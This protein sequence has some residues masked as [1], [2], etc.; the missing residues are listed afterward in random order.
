VTCQDAREFFSALV[1][2]A[3]ALEER[4]LLEAH[5]LS[6]A[7]CRRE[8]E[9]FRRTVALLRGVEP[10]RAPVG[11]VDRALARARPTPW[12]RRLLRRLFV[13]LPVKL[14]IEAAA[15]VLIAVSAVYVFQRTPELQQAARQEAPLRAPA[16]DAP[17]PA[18]PKPETAT[19]P[20][21]VP[22]TP[23]EPGPSAS[24]PA[25]SG[26]RKDKEGVTDLREAAPGASV[27]RDVAD[28]AGPVGRRESPSAQETKKTE[29]TPAAPSPLSKAPPAGGVGSAGAS[30]ERRAN[31]PEEKAESAPAAPPGS[32]VH[33]FSTRALV[34]VDVSGRLVVKDRQAAATALADLVARLGGSQLARRPD[35]GA[36]AGEIVE[37]LIPRAA[38][39]AFTQELGRLG[40]WR[41]D[42]ELPELPEL[43]R[44]VVHLTE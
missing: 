6:C 26:A 28:P 9:R 21:P 36:A 33:R 7:D 41:S 5:L 40:E 38:Y 4:A 29:A 43:V 3:L 22:T 27:S 8:L 31:A 2:E 25:P 39:A 1:D 42:T 30:R 13:P 14:P 15:V 20:R 17:L 35:P 19:P 24:P 11:F 44:A 23:R 37:I 34:S 18:P 16:A 10:A 32:T 12:Y